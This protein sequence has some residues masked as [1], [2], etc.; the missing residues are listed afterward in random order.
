[1]KEIRKNL[2]SKAGKGDVNVPRPPHLLL[3]IRRQK[4]KNMRVCTHP[5]YYN[6]EC[7]WLIETTALNVIGLLHCP[8]TNCPTTTW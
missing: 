8:I 5:R 3:V 4:H 6:F 1:M 2:H 7:D